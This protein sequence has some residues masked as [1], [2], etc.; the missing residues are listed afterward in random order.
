MFK[1]KYLKQVAFFFLTVFIFIVIQ[2]GTGMKLDLK[3]QLEAQPG[4]S[5]HVF[6]DNLKNSYPFDEEHAQRMTIEGDT[7]S[8]Q[9]PLKHANK[10][11]LDFDGPSQYVVIKDIEVSVL[12][13]II[14]HFTPDQI[15]QD[16]N[17]VND[18][19]LEVSGDS[20]VLN[21]IGEDSFIANNNINIRYLNPLIWGMQLFIASCLALCI[22]FIMQ[23]SIN[24]RSIRIIWNYKKEYLLISVFFVFICLPSIIGNIIGEQAYSENRQL[25]QKPEFKWSTLATYPR[26]YEDYYTDH[27]AF[28]NELSRLN[29]FLKYKLLNSSSGQYVIKGEDGWLFYNSKAKND[30]DT[31]A[32]YMGTNHYTLE[33][34][35]AIK[36]QV[37]DKQQ[38]LQAQ[39]ID[40]Y[41]F[42]AP[43][44]SNIYSSYMPK[45]YTKFN[46]TTRTDELV[47][48]LRAHTDIPI[49]YPKEEL[50]KASQSMGIYYKL[51]SHWN[52]LGAY[53]G[54]DILMKA[55]DP[56]YESIPIEK[57]TV[58]QNDIDTG[59][60]AGMIN[61]NG[62]LQDD[63]YTITDYKPEVTP[64]LTQEEGSTL[65]RY[66]SN[67]TNDEKLLMFRDS[68][69]SAWVPYFNKAFTESIF[70][71]SHQFDRA[72]I[73]QE[74]PDVVVLEM[75]ERYVDTL[76]NP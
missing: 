75:V 36:E 1:T 58:V 21:K 24:P 35:E 68:F 32:D 9:V 37:I 49:I 25:K 62:L 34:L 56:T 30:A 22:L 46:P 33:E 67:S 31:L 53:I 54:Y 66:T 3:L 42:I 19:Q 26:E 50:L 47:S 18:V 44:K 2:Y 74:K 59:D 55:I 70:I 48:Y 57:L 43:N 11:R 6:Y 29:S 7:L 38:Y 65:Y 40:F 72:L 17:E 4:E 76:K 10:I 23:N 27:L 64:Q 63:A 61:M 41:V 51:D 15:L 14:M 45:H 13:K 28:K 60:L 69:A 20:I 52:G 12:G 16:F 71:W 8:I 5:I 73:E 39:G